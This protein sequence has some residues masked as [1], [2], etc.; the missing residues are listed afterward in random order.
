M[1]SPPIADFLI[2]MGKILVMWEMH[3]SDLLY[4]GFR[5]GGLSESAV[6]LLAT[7]CEL[8]KSSRGY[9]GTGRDRC[10]GIIFDSDTDTDPETDKSQQQQFP[11]VRKSIFIINML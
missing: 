7:F 8:R 9:G 11:R 4:S 3:M 1:D 5:R 2:C 6:A 10:M